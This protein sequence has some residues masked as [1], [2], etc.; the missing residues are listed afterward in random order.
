MW[1]VLVITCTYF[2]NPVVSM[3][4]WRENVVIADVQSY[5]NIGSCWPAVG[6]CDLQ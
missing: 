6:E 2:D 4:E 5:I 3:F 1:T